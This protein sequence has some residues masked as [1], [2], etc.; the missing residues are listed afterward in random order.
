MYASLLHGQ[1]FPIFSSQLIS[2]FKTVKII[3]ESFLV[4]QNTDYVAKFHI[5]KK[6]AW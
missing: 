3:E 4:A 5:Y 6:C 2:H 1:V